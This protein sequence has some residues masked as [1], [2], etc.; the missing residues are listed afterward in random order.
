MGAS[1]KLHKGRICYMFCSSNV[2]KL[3]GSRMI[4]W[5]ICVAQ[6][7]QRKIDRVSTRMSEGKRLLERPRRRLKDC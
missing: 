5:A 6:M 4:T 2:S 1:R 7:G 3:T